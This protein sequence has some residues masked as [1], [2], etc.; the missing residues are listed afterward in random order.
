MN[1]KR[2]QQV[3]EI[4]K[5]AQQILDSATREAKQLPVAADQEA[6]Q[7]IEKARV[8]AQEEARQIVEKARAA[9]E[10]SRI[11]AE[12]EEKIRLFEKSAAAHFHHAVA[13]VIENVIGT[14]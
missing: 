8:A 2:I 1:E 14:E 13:Q 5:Q 3:L 4:E 11:V 10:T 7:L 6:Q 9:D 12:A